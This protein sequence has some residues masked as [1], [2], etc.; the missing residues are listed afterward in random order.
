M[1]KVLSDKQRAKNVYPVLE[2]L[3]S[4]IK[5]FKMKKKKVWKYEN[6]NPEVRHRL[7][8]E[9]PNNHECIISP[10]KT[11]FEYHGESKF[12]NFILPVSLTRSLINKQA[13]SKQKQTQQQQKNK[14]KELK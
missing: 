3:N 2:M 5:R 7:T 1:E 8:N 13:K 9:S 6:I 10:R 12:L 14:N 11:H 4:K